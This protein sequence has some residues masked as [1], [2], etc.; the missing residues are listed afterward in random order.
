MK[1]GGSCATVGNTE[2]DDPIK[3]RPPGLFILSETFS[4]AVTRSSEVRVLCHLLFPSAPTG[5]EGGLNYCLGFCK[6]V[7]F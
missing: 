1:R 4:F 7:F 6:I 5:D 2:F 3:W